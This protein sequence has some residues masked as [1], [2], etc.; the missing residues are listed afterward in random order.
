MC[1]NVWLVVHHRTKAFFTI[2]AENNELNIVDLFAFGDGRGRSDIATFFTDMQVSSLTSDISHRRNI[3]FFTDF[4]MS[5]K[6]PKPT[7]IRVL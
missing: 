1:W 5:L 6:A 7:D 3:S 2:A 4:R